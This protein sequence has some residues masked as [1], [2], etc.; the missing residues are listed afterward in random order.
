MWIASPPFL[1]E[2]TLSSRD[3][4]D[5][6]VENGRDNPASTR[7]GDLPEIDSTRCSHFSIKIVQLNIPGVYPPMQIPVYRCFLAELLVARMRLTPEGA[8]LAERLV[9][10]PLD[11]ETRLLCGPDLEAITTTSCSADRYH[12]SCLVG[13]SQIISDLGLDTSLE[14]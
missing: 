14:E 1:N 12:R 3:N 2:F 7:D 11:G 10:P 4:R 9:A 5:K 6:D 8:A 13:F